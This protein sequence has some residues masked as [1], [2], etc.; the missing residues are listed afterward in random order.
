MIDVSVPESALQI[1]ECCADRGCALV[2][3][4]T[5]FDGAQAERVRALG[6]SIPIVWAPN[7][8]LAANLATKLARVAA[9]ML[10]TKSGGADVEILERHHRFKEDA[11]SGTALRVGQI[12]ADAMR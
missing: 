9:E 1:A 11:P 6:R 12:I 5:G 7:M 8:S 2:L 10:A 3:A 4:T